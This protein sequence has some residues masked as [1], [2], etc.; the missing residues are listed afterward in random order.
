MALDCKF[1]VHAGIFKFTHD[2]A[3]EKAKKLYAKA[4]DKLMNEELTKKE[5]EKRAKD[6]EEKVTRELTDRTLQMNLEGAINEVISKRNK[7]AWQR[8]I[9]KRG[10]CKESQKPQTD[11]MGWVYNQFV[12]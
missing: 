3:A 11:R 1:P 9:I 4:M 6:L 2:V 12:M 5:N 8:R 7:K 10:I